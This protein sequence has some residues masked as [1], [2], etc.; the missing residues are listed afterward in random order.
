MVFILLAGVA[1]FCLA[2]L[3][4]VA[5][6]VVVFWGTTAEIACLRPFFGRCTANVRMAFGL[7]SGDVPWLFGRCSR[8]VR[9]S[10]LFMV[11][12]QTLYGITGGL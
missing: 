8:F 11:S 1:G 3:P 10:V 2:W 9:L 4:A 5:L 6:A 7:C 12:A